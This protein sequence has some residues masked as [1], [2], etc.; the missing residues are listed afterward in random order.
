MLQWRKEPITEKVILTGSTRCKKKC[1]CLQ[2]HFLDTN[3]GCRGLISCRHL[4]LG[5]TF[6]F[7]KLG[8]S[9]SAYYKFQN[10]NS[11]CCHFRDS[12]FSHTK[13]VSVNFCLM[14]VFFILKSIK[15][16]KCQNSLY[17]FILSYISWKSIHN[18]SHNRFS[19]NVR[20]ETNKAISWLYVTKILKTYFFH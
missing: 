5:G 18:W 2:T 12:I 6:G 8:F 7:L 4:L 3:F 16:L 14:H 1:T 17:L 10:T 9:F 19:C 13:I 15:L 20:F 11:E